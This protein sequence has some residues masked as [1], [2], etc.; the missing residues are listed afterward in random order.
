MK[1]VTKTKRSVLIY[2][3]GIPIKV[4]IM[5]MQVLNILLSNYLETKI[6][7]KETKSLVQ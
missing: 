2:S 1:P 7:R 6:I 4:M 3:A 5:I